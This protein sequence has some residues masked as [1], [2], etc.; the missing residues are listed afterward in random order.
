M[1][2]RLGLV[3]FVAS[4]RASL[5][6]DSDLHANSTSSVYPAGSLADRVAGALW[7]ML[8]ADALAS[9]AHWFYGGASQ[10]IRTFGGP[11]TD[12]VQPVQH[13][14][15]FPGSI[16]AL[17]DT[18]GAGRGSD[19]GDIV[20][21]VINHGKKQY[22]QRGSN[23]HYHCTL[24]KGENTLEGELTRLMVRHLT[25]QVGSDFDLDA[26]Q[27]EY[28]SFM[29][30]AGSH[31]DAYCNS[32]HRLFFQRRAQGKPLRECPSNDGHNVDAI[33]GLILPSVVFLG[34]FARTLSRGA[35][36]SDP[37]ATSAILEQSSRQAQLSVRATR[38]SRPVE[39]HVEQHYAPIYAAV[40]SGVPLQEAVAQ[41]PLGRHRQLGVGEDPVVACYL[42]SNFESLLH[43]AKK[44]G[45]N[46]EAA[47]LANANSGGENVHRGLVLGALLGAEAGA[48]GISDKWRT[49]LVNFD[50]LQL[51]IREFVAAAT[52]DFSRTGRGRTDL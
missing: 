47:V 3:L 24:K 38:K 16:M 18:S 30:T 36:T 44:Y 10:I 27:S 41:S 22:W 6:V 31:N 12:Y 40:L 5:D 29:T 9:P 46:F 19:E 15:G 21:T 42:D 50:A 39:R 37:T 8:I 25:R 26:F 33:D 17:S 20:G 2:L 7:G 51:E 35:A 13:R 14:G 43:L 52:G 49:G 4:A 34:T 48:S 45:G 32:Y 1:L 23:Y 11:L 28:V